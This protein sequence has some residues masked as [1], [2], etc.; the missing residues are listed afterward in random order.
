MKPLSILIVACV[1]ASTACFAGTRTQSFDRDPDWESHDNHIVPK[2]Y[3]TVTQ[4][5]GYSNTNHAGKSQGEMGGMVTRASE[6][7][8]YADK[9]APATLDEKLSASGSFALTQ[10]TSGGGIFFGF[11][12]A[13]Q[14]GAGG[15]PI[16]SL[17]LDMG[18]EKDGARLAVRLIT[19]KNQS[20]GTFITPFIPGKF[21]P[22]AIRN[23]G[24][25]YTW[26]LDYDPQAAAGRGQ[27]TFTIHGDAPKPGELEKPDMPDNFRAEAQKR[28]PSTTSFTVDLPEGYKQQ[29]TTFDHFG[30][31]NMM[32][33]G[34][35]V[36]I[37]FDDLEYAG[38]SQ[39]FW[40][41]PNFDAAGNRA[42]YQSKD[43]GGAHNFGYSETNNAGGAKSG[44]IGGT[45][46]RAE[47]WGYY[48]DK[49]ETLSFDDRLEAHGKIMMAAAGPDADMSFGWFH[50]DEG[51]AADPQ[52]SGTFLGIHV[53]GPTR[54]G[55]YFM[56]VFTVNEKL[57][58]TAPKAPLLQAGKTCDWFLIYDPAA[59]NGDGAITA[60]LADE[61]IT[62]NLKPGQKA[63]A[64]DARLDH[65]GMFSLAA[66][67][68]MVKI[69]LDD[70]SYT[71]APTK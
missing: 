3:P 24:T 4:D 34:G 19:A 26:K 35:H 17:G 28:F 68:Q 52:K 43:A 69:Y 59:N 70:I 71:A 47:R 9:I 54:V 21:R 7:A 36:K 39:D 13:K 57:R 18:S 27:F 42:T 62:L 20:C 8:F 1:F 65:F 6:P 11:F 33:P 63:K 61:S 38:R 31:M 23:D 53:G 51:A 22:T 16:A 60:T 25:R 37:Y 56:P 41:D 15:R 29:G 49:I 66:G 10:T 12:N 32:K 5:F 46:W 58:G 40:E 45:F 48:G 44:E 14:P 67:G 55:H 2:A 30:I 64:K 50:T